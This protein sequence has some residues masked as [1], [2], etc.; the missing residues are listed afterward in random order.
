MSNLIVLI[1]VVN[2]YIDCLLIKLIVDQLVS[3]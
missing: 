2:L 3:K 1:S